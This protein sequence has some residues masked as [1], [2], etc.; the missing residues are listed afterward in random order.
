MKN[1]KIL[2]VILSLTLIFSTVGFG[3]DVTYSSLGGGSV[4]LQA[5]KGKVV[6]LAVGA[7]WLPL[8][9]N[10]VAITNKLAK[11]Y[12]G[13]DVVFYFVATDSTAAKSKN[14]ASNEDVQAFGTRTKLTSSILRDS[15]GATTLKRFK[16]DQI[17]A[18]IIFDKD[19]KPVSEPFG[20]ITPTAE[21]E[22][23]LVVL[24]SKRI[25]QVL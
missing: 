25:D 15:D 9:K 10:Q 18:F 6:V 24:I 2:F 23:D 13:R 1:I 17:P 16:I 4:S 11:K 20:G 21:A 12:A 19:G 22:N 14:F 5:Q 8:S 7:T 3:Q